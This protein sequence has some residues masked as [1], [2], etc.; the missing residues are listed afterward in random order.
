MIIITL[1]IYITFCFYIHD[2]M[3][4]CIECGTRI[5]IDNPTN[6]IVVDCPACGTE[7]EIFEGNLPGLHLGPSEE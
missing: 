6:Q 1:G 5:D 4:M 2:N 7:L 3:F